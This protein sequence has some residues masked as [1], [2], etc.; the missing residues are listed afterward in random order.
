M[1]HSVPFVSKEDLGL[2]NRNGAP[3]PLPGLSRHKAKGWASSY[4]LPSSLYNW[5]LQSRLRGAPAF[6][7]LL[8]HQCLKDIS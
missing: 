6:Y 7:L 8:L 4:V 2:R 5:A 3:S 1:G